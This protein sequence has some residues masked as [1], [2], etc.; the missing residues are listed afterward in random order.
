[1]DPT[2]MKI[3]IVENH[4]FLLSYYTILIAGSSEL[5]VAGTSASFREALKLLRRE[6]VDALITCLGTPI[7]KG[8]DFIQEAKQIDPDM[9]IMINTFNDSKHAIL[10]GLRSGA[11]GYILKGSPPLEFLS[12]IDTLKNGGVPL[13]PKVGRIIISHLHN[14]HGEPLRVL[15]H[16][17][18][19]VLRYLEKNLTYKEVAS[20]LN[21]STH[22]VHAHVKKIY[23]KLKAQGREEAFLKAR[24][25]GLL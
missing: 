17:E 8:M 19:H 3:F 1:M 22:T 11:T 10:T 2:D 5:E 13:S 24:K 9:D 16:M 15:S 7:R 6:K 25:K 23:F 14:S 18:L 12:S 21:I 20:R 4:R